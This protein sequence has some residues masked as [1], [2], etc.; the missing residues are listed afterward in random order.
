MGACYCKVCGRAI[1][2][3]DDC[4]ALD[5]ADGRYSRRVFFCRWRCLAVF[6]L[7][8]GDIPRARELHAGGGSMCGAGAE[9]ARAS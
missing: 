2:N 9:T 3:S 5:G 1:G 4:L 6:S 7:A 8:E